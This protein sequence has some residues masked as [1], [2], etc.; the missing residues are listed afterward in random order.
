MAVVKPLKRENGI[1]KQF[2]NTDTIDT[3]L[4]SAHIFVGSVGN[5]ATDVAMSGDVTI[6]NTGVT[7]IS[8][9]VIIDNDINAS[10]AINAIKIANGSVSNSEFEC[11]NGVTSA[12]QTQINTKVTK[13]GDSI[14]ATLTIGTG[15]NNVLSLITN[16]NPTIYAQTNKRIALNHSSPQSTLHIYGDG[17]NGANGFI[18]LAILF[19][20]G[21]LLMFVLEKMGVRIVMQWKY[22]LRMVYI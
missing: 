18:F 13:G 9:G 6:N 4:T 8:A 14:A 19:L 11:L 22:M 7:D 12:I 1:T 20:G 17:S 15:D 3:P 5:V 2:S 10:A 21:L 16:N